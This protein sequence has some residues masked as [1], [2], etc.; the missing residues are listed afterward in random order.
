MWTCKHCSRDV[1]DRDDECWNCGRGKNW[2][3]GEPNPLPEV[4]AAETAIEKPPPPFS[5]S[6]T[7]ALRVI[8][9]AV[10][11]AGIV[12]GIVVLTNSPNAPSDIAVQF[13]NDLPTQI[14][15]ANRMIYLVVGWAQIIGA[16]TT[17]IFLYV[18]AGIGDAVLDL[19]AARHNSDKPVSSTQ[20]NNSLDASGG[21]VSRN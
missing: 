18:V 1:S 14:Q 15:S 17:G 12:G 8:A 9:F 4:L 10:A 20:S 16:I 7:G 19:W 5:D 6:A 3:P 11:I 21:S 13:G 2:K